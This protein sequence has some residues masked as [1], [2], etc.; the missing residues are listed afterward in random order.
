MSAKAEELSEAQKARIE[1]NRIKALHLRQAKLISHPY[2]KVDDKAQTTIKI[3]GTKY[4]DSGGGFL[5]EEPIVKDSKDEKQDAQ[6]APQTENGAIT[7][8][9]TYEQ[10]LECGRDFFESNLLTNFE[11][12][13][14]DDCRDPDDKHSLI[15][16]TE[17]KHEYLLKDC[18]LD[19]REPPLKF[20]A[21]KNPHDH[22][23]G[24]MKL[25][26][27]LQVEKR[28][29]EVWGSEEEIIKQRELREDKREISKIKKYNKKMKELRMDM[30]S[31]LYDRTVKA[32]HT[33]S[34]GEE[35]YN[36]EEDTYTHTCTE[37]GFVETFEKM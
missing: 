37:C 17:A 1:R 5:V 31:S 12:A 24:E 26:L 23:W 29:L 14:C 10:C 7:I 28:A 15:T 9:V 32:S 27:H 2:A 16:K 36:E 30:R 11:Y 20:I 6:A 18:D 13:V 35:T 4:I 19:R 33:H 3:Q 22:R 34:Y 25:Y 8:P 21:R